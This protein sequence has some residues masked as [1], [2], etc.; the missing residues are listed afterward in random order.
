MLRD[1]AVGT[2]NGLHKWRRAAG[3]VLVLALVTCVG[4]TGAGGARTTATAHE[5]TIGALLDLRDGWTSLGRASEVTL[6]VGIADANTRLARGGS[7]TRVR[8]QVID[9]HGDPGASLRALRRFAAEGVR[10]VIGPE[11]SSEVRAV[12]R[13]ADSLGVLLISQGSTAHSLA[14]RGDN[15]FRLVPDDVRE[16]EALV[17]LLQRDGIDGI[18]PVWRGDA[19][20][21]GLADSVRRRF[22]RAGG[23]VANGVPY[24]TRVSSFGQIVGLVHTEV[25]SLRSQGASR[26]AVYLA[27]FDEVAHVFDAASSDPLLRSL[28]WYGSDGV[29]LSPRLVADAKAA[30]FAAAVGYP[31][32]ILGIDDTAARRASKVVRRIQAKLGRQPDAF[33]LT[34]YDALQVAVTAAA[35]AGGV[36]DVARLRQ[37][38]ADVAH[39]YRGVTGTLVL[40]AAGDRAYGSYDFWSVCNRGASAAWQRVW[41]YVATA[42]DRGRI[43]ARGHCSGA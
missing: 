9:V 7:A 27:G 5:L 35:R 29:A 19:G 42:P 24:G 14:I 25:A 6:R 2:A 17:A 28:P 3:L 11:A 31:S 23:A 30:S 33:A 12:G 40:N 34:A 41:S 21:T 22:S 13:A 43:V 38:V 8:L 36:G 1:L 32:P 18:V 37:F 26:V 39:G 4:Q 10:I 15:V 16:S 20:N